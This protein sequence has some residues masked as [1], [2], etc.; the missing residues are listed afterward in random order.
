MELKPETHMD[1]GTFRTSRNTLY[2]T[3]SGAAVEKSADYC[4]Q[5]SSLRAKQFA[6]MS[7][8]TGMM[9]GVDVTWTAT[10]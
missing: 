5:G 10:K 9:S 3:A 7:M 4:V 8:D 2:T 6:S 1:T